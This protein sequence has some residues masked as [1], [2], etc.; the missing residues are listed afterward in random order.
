MFLLRKTLCNSLNE[1]LKKKEE[2]Q[3]EESPSNSK[4]ECPCKLKF[5]ANF[6]KILRLQV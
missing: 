1:K 5:A 3:E 4:L 2:Q 6:G